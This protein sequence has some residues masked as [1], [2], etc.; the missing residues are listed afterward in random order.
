MIMKKENATNNPIMNFYLKT[1]SDLEEMNLISQQEKSLALQF[2]V[3]L[4][5][6]KITTQKLVA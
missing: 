1:L 5:L 3:D 4:E 6:Q 2:L